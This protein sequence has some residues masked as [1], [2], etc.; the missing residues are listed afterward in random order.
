M[1]LVI[2]L[3][4]FD[5]FLSEFH[6]YS[7][8]MMKCLEILINS[9]RKVRKKAENSGIGAKFH[10]FISFFQSHPYSVVLVQKKCSENQVL[11]DACWA[12]S[13]LSDG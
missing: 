6:G 12:L 13:Y 7:Q 3:R 4:N 11:A 10:C 5:G 2:F 9:A 8:K 1:N